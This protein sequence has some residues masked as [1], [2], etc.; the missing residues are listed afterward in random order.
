MLDLETG[1]YRELLPA[2]EPTSSGT[3]ENF[4]DLLLAYGDGMVAAMRERCPSLHGG[5]DDV[6]L[7]PM[8]RS[9]FPAQASAVRAALKL[10]ARGET[11]LVLGEIGSG[12]TSVALQAIWSLADPDRYAPTRCRSSRERSGAVLCRACLRWACTSSR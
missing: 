9:L 6:P 3:I 2:T 8:A 4:A 7:R 12:K 11:P 10:I 5:E 1:K